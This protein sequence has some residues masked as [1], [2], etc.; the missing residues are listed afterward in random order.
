M[1][2]KQYTEEELQKFKAEDVKDPRFRVLYQI[3]QKQQEIL[4]K[5]EDL[6]IYI[7]QA[8]K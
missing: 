7:S 6:L 4:D 5:I 2:S 1:M 8:I 3:L